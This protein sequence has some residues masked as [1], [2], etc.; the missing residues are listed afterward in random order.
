MHKQRITNKEFIFGRNPII[1]ALRTHTPLEKIFLLHGTHGNA[2]EQIRFLAKQRGIVCT[3]IS[4]HRL[5]ELSEGE[6]TQGVIALRSAKQY[7]EVEDI[8]NIATEKGEQPFVLILD[9]IEDPHNVGAII[10]TAECC[11]VH[12]II[13]P[14]HNSASLTSTVSKSSAGAIEY[15]NIAKVTN[16]VS[17]ITELQERGIWI[18]GTDEKAPKK[19]SDYDFSSPVAIVVG[20]EGKGVRKL[21]KEHCDELL[22]IPLQGKISSLNVS[23]AAGII[24]YEVVR[25]R[26]NAHQ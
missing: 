4:H 18:I 5:K 6:E 8:L 17:T 15:V 7:I 10:R 3:E 13:V 25:K 23:V 19:F 26:R 14:K 12:G 20:N 2:I 11:G 16:I 1:E 24:L 9:E 22:H 21:V